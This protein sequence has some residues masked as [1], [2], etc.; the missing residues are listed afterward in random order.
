MSDDRRQRFL[1]VAPKRI[2]KVL[3]DIRLLSHCSNTN[4]YQYTED[5]VKQCFSAIR[6]EIN[7]AEALFESKSKKIK[8]FKFN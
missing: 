5:E 7:K 1:K 6:E 4:N 3:E 8:D 2:N